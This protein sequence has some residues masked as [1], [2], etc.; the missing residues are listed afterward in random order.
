[1]L[2]DLFERL[3]KGERLSPGDVAALRSGV[4]ALERATANIN[5]WVRGSALS[6]PEFN[7][8]AA[9]FGRAPTWGVSF[10]RTDNQAV[11]HQTYTPIS[12]QTTVNLE[13]GHFKWLSAAATKIY[14]I[15]PKSC[16]LGVVVNAAWAAHGDAEHREIAIGIYDTADSLQERITLV[17]I[18]DN[19]ASVIPAAGAFRWRS[20]GNQGYYITVEL[21][22]D[23]SS[24]SHTVNATA[25][26]TVFML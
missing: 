4:A 12:W 2:E 5:S 1:M 22:H 18:S 26:A 19:I 7:A 13:G 6:L 16:L 3:A 9:H 11:A 14:P 15:V 23:D 24:G 8:P 17:H 10:A 25:N 20:Y 21:Y